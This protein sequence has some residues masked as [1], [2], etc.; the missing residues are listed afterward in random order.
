[1][2]M[3]WLYDD[4][5]TWDLSSIPP[6][7]IIC[8]KIMIFLVFYESVTDGP[9]DGS[10]DGPTDGR[11]DMPG[12]R[13]A[14]THL[15]MEKLVSQRRLKS[16][17]SNSN[18]SWTVVVAAWWKYS[19]VSYNMRKFYL[20]PNSLSLYHFALP[21]EEK[22]VFSKICRNKFSHVVWNS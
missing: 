16:R 5:I 18:G 2:M 6:P 4:V 14:R 19:T 10:T 15:K 13:D 12:Y 11:T 21:D 20:L 1:M 17:I 3:K 7:T 9:T 8:S 22:S